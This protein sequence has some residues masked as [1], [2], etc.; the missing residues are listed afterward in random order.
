MKKLLAR[1]I[2]INTHGLSVR[3]FL[4][5][6]ESEL[7]R[8]HNSLVIIFQNMLHA[9]TL[10]FMAL[11]FYCTWRSFL[12]ALG[13]KEPQRPASFISPLLQQ[14]PPCSTSLAHLRHLK[15]VPAVAGL[16]GSSF[17]GVT[18]CFTH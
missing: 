12:G 15:L 11:P 6:A 17:L 18:H 5:L 2:A 10:S 7:Q 4:L 9:E 13:Q 1:N 3:Y 14:S 16:K 8:V